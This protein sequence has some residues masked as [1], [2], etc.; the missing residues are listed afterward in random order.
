MT[1]VLYE[2]WKKASNLARFRY[3]YGLFVLIGCWI[4]FILLIM[5]VVMYSK[6]LS[7]NPGTYLV[8]KLNVNYCYCYGDDLIYLINKT[9]ISYDR[10][11]YKGG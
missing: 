6:E 3:K 4:C 10:N 9:D 2:E 7:A 11:I 5:F 1:D 8:K